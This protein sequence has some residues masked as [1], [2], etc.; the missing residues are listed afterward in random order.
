MGVLPVPEEVK[1]MSRRIDD[2][3]RTVEAQ[4]KRIDRIIEE[5][6]GVKDAVNSLAALGTKLDTMSGTLTTTKDALRMLSTTV[7]RKL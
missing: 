5:I 6:S 2:I 7:E 4:Q 1:D 3:A